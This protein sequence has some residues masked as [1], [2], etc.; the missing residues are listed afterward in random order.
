MKIITYL[1]IS[2]LLIYEC[3][4]GQWTHIGFSDKYLSALFAKD[5]ELF[6]GQMDIIYRSFDD[7]LNFDTVA[8]LNTFEVSSFN[9]TGNTLFAVT[10]W[11][12]IWPIPN[13]CIFRLP[14][15]IIICC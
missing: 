12:S 4:L 1:S 2:I 3:A 9:R 8:T 6:V 7:G 11:L 15:N 14:C 13:A 5:N 10:S